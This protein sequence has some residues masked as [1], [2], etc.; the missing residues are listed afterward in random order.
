MTWGV[1]AY[2]LLSEKLSAA[3]SLYN[4]WA[5][6]SLDLLMTIFWLS[7]MGAN[8]AQRASFVYSVNVDYCW[9]DGSTVNSNHC[10]V[11]KRD[12][13]KRA[14]VAGPVALAVMSAIAGLSALVM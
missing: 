6:L 7:S 2:T 14:A 4:I 9:N 13:Q 5:V 11:S 8:A 1:V 10:V 12:L 3:R